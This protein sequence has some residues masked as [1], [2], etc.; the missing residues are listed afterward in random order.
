MGA[1]VNHMEHVKTQI[2]YAMLVG[3]IAVL[4]GFIPVGLGMPIGIVLPI[5]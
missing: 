2:P 5:R 3:S 1:G 4:F